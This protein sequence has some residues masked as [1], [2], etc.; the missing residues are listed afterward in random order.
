[1]A[2]ADR[3]P[4]GHIEERANGSFRATVFAGI[5]PVTGTRRYIKKTAATRREAE[6]E[7]TRLQ[8]QVDERRH[9]RS[10]ITVSQAL[11]Q[12]LEVAEHEPSTR[13]RYEQLIRLYIEPTLGKQP[14]AKVDAEILERLYARLMRCRKL[15]AGGPKRGHECEPL[16]PNTVRKIHFIVR[17]T[18]ERAVRW[19]YLAVNEAAMAEPPAFAQS[20]PDPPS[21]AEA[22][23][24]LNEASR[25]PEWALLLWL[26]MVAG[27]RRG[28]ACALRWTDIDLER[29]IITIARSHHGREE[30]STKTRQRRQIAVDLATVEML[31]AHRAQCAADC[32]KLGTALAQDAFVFS[33]APDH[34]IPLLPH[35]VS[36]RYRRLAERVGLRSSRL[37]ALRH[38]SATELIAAGVDVRTVAGR[39]GHG[40]GGAI[41][42]KVYAGW[43]SEADRR[44]AGT[45]A[46]I[47]PL[48]DPT[49]RQPR[50]LAE[51]IAHQ[52]RDDIRN[53]ALLS[54]D[55]L[56]TV[57]ELAAA[58]GVAQGTINRA[59]A[60][61]KAEGLIE[62]QRGQRA[63]IAA[64]TL[65]Q[66]L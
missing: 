25:D 59:M 9:P 46:G 34:S 43:S 19:K 42:L 23:A 52:I 33:Q 18:F 3:R 56:P 41:T 11:E 61:M 26:T 39:L 36:Q 45:I 49:Q 37:H 60:I 8:N 10:A 4:R 27:W 31:A 28:E 38:Y 58:H 48:P 47:V 35:S 63:T 15:C 5:D 66:E 62:V 44:A 16:A 12:W 17:T 40:S 21:A 7:L 50:G 6:I 1:M 2:R 20:D 29:G 24:L 54:G 64:R 55:K 30:K 32:T 14:I 53:G 57:V 65:T 51:M 22:A 13:E